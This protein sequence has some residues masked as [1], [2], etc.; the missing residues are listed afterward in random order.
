MPGALRI[1]TGLK[2]SSSSLFHSFCVTA[3]FC[4]DQ[5]V[6]CHH[7]RIQRRGTGSSGL[8]PR[9]ADPSVYYSWAPS[10]RTI[11]K[12]G[13]GSR[14]LV[15]GIRRCKCH[16]NY[17][18]HLPVGTMSSCCVSTSIYDLLTGFNILP[19]RWSEY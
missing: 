8:R 18:L 16:L 9:V 6:L 5:N 19:M 14:R 2:H 12:Q 3:V 15:Y 7:A 4:V 17:G 10:L 1:L 11:V 13:L